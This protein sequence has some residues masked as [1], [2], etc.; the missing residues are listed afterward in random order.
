MGNVV[1]YGACNKSFPTTRMLFF[2][3]SAQGIQIFR[4][5]LLTGQHLFDG[6]QFEDGAEQGGEGAVTPDRRVHFTHDFLSFARR[7]S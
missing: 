1:I 2:P 6:R 5:N 3:P 4:F 7:H